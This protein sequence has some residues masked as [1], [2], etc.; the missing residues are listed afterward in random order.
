VVL[1]KTP[2][3]PQA[4]LGAWRSARVSK[5]APLVT[6]YHAGAAPIGEITPHL[7]KELGTA[8]Q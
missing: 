5:L 2:L 8:L 4:S 1:H 6:W 3:L 7:T